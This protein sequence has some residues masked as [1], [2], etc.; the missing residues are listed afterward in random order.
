MGLTTINWAIMAVYF[1]FVLGICA[2]IK[3]LTLRTELPKGN[4]RSPGFCVPTPDRESYISP[5]RSAAGARDAHSVDKR[6]LTESKL[7][8]QSSL[9]HARSAADH[10]CGSANCGGRATAH[11]CRDLAEVPAALIAHRISKVRVVEEIEEVRPEPQMDSFGP[12]R[13][14]LGNRKIV[15]GQAWAVILVAP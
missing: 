15:V 14:T 5:R 2:A 11:S 6:V 4:Q 12:Q 3:R 10:A 9:D 13:K 7:D 1:A 8:A